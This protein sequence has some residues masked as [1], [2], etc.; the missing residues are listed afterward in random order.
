MVVSFLKKIFPVLLFSTVL[1]F[2]LF[3]QNPADST[4][5]PFAIADE[6]KLSAEDLANKKEGVYVTGEPDISSDPVDG[7]GIGVEGSLF[8]DGKKSDPFFNYTP[9]RTRLDFE[10]F[11]TTK[12]QRVAK[13]KLDIPY[14]FNTKWRL[15]MEAAYEVNPNLL[16]FGNDETSLNTLQHPHTGKTYENFSDYNSSLSNIRQVTSS[17]GNVTTVTDKFYNTY[18]KEEAIFNMSA[19]HSYLDSKLRLLAGYEFA[20]IN[21]STFDNNQTDITDVNGNTVKNGL[22]KVSDDYSSHK[23]LGYGSN[24]ISQLQLGI[25]YDTR[26]LETDPSK[27]IFAEITNEFS[28]SAL[29]SSFNYDKVFVH[30]KFYTQLFPSVFKKLIFASRIGLGYTAGDAPFYEYQDEWSSEGSIEGLGGAHTIRGYKQ[31]RF[32]GRVMNFENIELRW[33]FAQTNFLKQHLAFSAVP[34]IDAGAAWNSFDRIGSNL[35]NFRYSPGLGLRIAWDVN[36]IL[37]FDYAVSN[38]DAQ[39][40]FNIGHAF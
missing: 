26:D 5:L 21:I 28:N 31:A 20:W 37:R 17:N 19:E 6:K 32:L 7:F 3:A 13:I 29:G 40:F 2:Q 11:Y 33:R 23:I 16:Y 39:F 8:F 34:F 4:R 14:I 9:Y 36:T 24:I 12:L 15:R 10:V 35:N 27:G 30:G 18:Q 38:E 22:S 1:Q 25:V